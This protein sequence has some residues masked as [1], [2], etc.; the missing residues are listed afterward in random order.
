MSFTLTAKNSLW[1]LLILA[2]LTRLTWLS[3]PN[4]VIFDEV[5]FGKFITAYC[6][7][8]ERFFDIHPPHVKL[9]IAGVG[10]LFG[11]QGGFDFKNIG[12]SYGQ[13]PVWPLRLVPALSGVLL[14]LILFILMRQLGASIAAA[15]LVGVA[16]VFDNALVIQS[17]VISLD[18]V[19]LAATFGSMTAFLAGVARPSPKNMGWF[20]LC[21]ALVGLAVGAKFTGLSAAV[22]VT[23]LVLW[24]AGKEANA[25]SATT[26]LVRFLVITVSALAIYS[27]GWWLHYAL[28]P[29]PGSGD[30]WQTVSDNVVADTLAMHTIMFNA[31]YNLTATHPHSS[32]WWTWP[33][34]LRPV[35]Y[36][37]GVGPSAIYFLGNPVVWWGAA[38]LFLTALVGVMQS[39]LVE[40]QGRRAL[41]PAG[42]FLLAGFFIV[43]GPLMRVPRALFLYHYVTPL[44]FSLLFGVW[45]LDSVPSD[46]TKRQMWKSQWLW[47]IIGLTVIGFIFFSPI[48]YGFTIPQW[49]WDHLFWLRTWR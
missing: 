42:W 40:R 35:F 6:C 39:V 8:G 20:V 16:V 37:Q 38:L 49:W 30:A 2:A 14:P 19:L 17:R 34:M 3:Y 4:Q 32:H 11:Y 1:V 48:T 45:W 18:G 22:M 46:V 25:P 31:N 47:P 41:A 36:W 24:Q 15:L 33:V 5:H 12:E 43:F 21:G 44:V 7:T 23:L 27:L 13:I 29:L 10:R 28:L 9:M 26:W